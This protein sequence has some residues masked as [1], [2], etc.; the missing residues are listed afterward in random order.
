MNHC[1]GLGLRGLLAL[2]GPRSREAWAYEN[3]VHLNCA[4][5]SA[6]QPELADRR[7]SLAAEA[8]AVEAVEKVPAP[9]GL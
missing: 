6:A 4:R 1:I 2:R 8:Q 5:V 3:T 9:L 7:A